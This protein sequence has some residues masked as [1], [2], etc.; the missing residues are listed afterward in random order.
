MTRDRGKRSTRGH[1]V[2]AKYLAVD[3]MGK[4]S[5]CQNGAYGAERSKAHLRLHKR[6]ELAHLF[7]KLRV[8]N[9]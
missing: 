4:A 5:Y 1:K 2:N 8:N 7:V 6:F 9:G 3:L